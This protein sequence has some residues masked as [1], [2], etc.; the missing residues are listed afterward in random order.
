MYVR[1]IQDTQQADHATERHLAKC[2][3]QLGFDLDDLG[4]SKLAKRCH[5]TGKHWA[6]PKFYTDDFLQKADIS[7]DRMERLAKQILV[8]IDKL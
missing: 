3:T 5:I 6:D 2:W 7:L 8:D 4:L 1:Q